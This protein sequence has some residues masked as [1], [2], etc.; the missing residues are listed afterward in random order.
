[1]EILEIEAREGY[2]FNGG[3]G[4][5]PYNNNSG[6]RTEIS[7]RNAVRFDDEIKISRTE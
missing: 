2:A 1:M 6:V 5:R 3:V 7:N 4:F